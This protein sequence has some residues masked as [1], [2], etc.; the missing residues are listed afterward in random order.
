MNNLEKYALV[1]QAMFGIGKGLGGIPW[2]EGA[3]V[4]A[5]AM[6]HTAGYGA[7]LGALGNATLGD[8]NEELTARILKGLLYG[9]GGG[10]AASIPLGVGAMTGVDKTIGAWFRRRQAMRDLNRM[11]PENL[12]N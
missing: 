2:R 8:E 11:Q 9:A 4:G 5:A 12:S 6:P 1:K 10:A 3:Q 7:L